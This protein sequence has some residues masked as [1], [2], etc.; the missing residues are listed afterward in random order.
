M[1]F[2]LISTFCFLLFASIG[3]GQNENNVLFL[4]STNRQFV[5]FVTIKDQAT[6]EVFVADSL[7]K[8]S[9]KKSGNFLASCIGFE[10]TEFEFTLGTSVVVILP[11]EIT[12][13]DM[14][15]ISANRQ[16]SKRTEAPIAIHKL[17]AKILDETKAT[18]VFEAI[19]KIPGVLT[20]NLNNEQHMMSIRLPVSTSA[21]YL[22]MEDGVPVRPMGVFNHNALI[23]FNQFTVSAIEVV[24]G[25]S[26]SIYGPEGIGGTINFISEK[27]TKGA[28]AKVGVQLD[29]WGYK[30]IQYALGLTKGKASLQLGGIYSDQKNSWMSRT[31]YTKNAFFGR[32]DYALTQKTNLNSTLSYSNYDSQT[33]GNIDSIGF[34]SRTYLA[35]NNFS[36]RKSYA[37]RLKTSLDHV[38]N[39]HTSS[40][41]TLFARNNAL[42][43]NPAYSIRWTTGSNTARGEINSNDFTSLGFIGQHNQK[44][45]FLKANLLLGISHDRSPN[46][47]NSYQIDLNAELQ[48]DK[49]SVKTY[50]IAKERPDIAL[51][52][53]KAIINNSAVYGQ[54]Q[55]EPIK[56]LQVTAGLRYDLM[57]FSFTN[58]IDVDKTTNKAL[59]G[60][61]VYDNLTP[62]VGLV[63][64]YS[65]K[66]GFYANYS[67]GFAPPSLTA[68]FR[69]RPAALPNGDLFY[70]NLNP[71][72]FTNQEVGLWYS[73]WKNKAYIDLSYYYMNGRNELLNIRQPDNSF[74]YQSAGK[75]THQGLEFS[76]NVKP[77]KQFTYRIGGAYSEHVF[78]EFLLSTRAADLVKNVNGK[79]MP[80]APQFVANSEVSY[81]PA[82]VKNSRISLE[83]QRVGSYFQNQIN[84][85]IYQ[86]YHL[87]NARFG[88]KYKMAEVYTNV[89]NLT[90][91]LYANN[92]SRGNA[93]TDRSNFTPA[94][95]RTYVIGLQF[96][97]LNP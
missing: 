87:W 73:F 62:K 81:Y 56:K 97:F 76:L 15:V 65:Q 26:S 51:A 86:G 71:A 47:Y 96:N 91:I 42:G 40:F 74:D 1:N 85:V 77:S 49:K 6:K 69:K 93:S 25:P 41:L 31:D 59:T 46:T 57:N 33:G 50:T 27:A 60:E 66:L 43:Q 22:Y 28:S 11:A 38:W 95:P 55:L 16:V 21:Y 13:L 34:Y 63:Y 10:T 68:I 45:T 37:L 8:F 64:N 2:R 30:R 39:K 61:K 52:N 75:T 35:N 4:E 3:F 70:Y 72:Q 24:K 90:D 89:L 18:G 80:N 92:V 44:F 94:A 84:T 83:Y 54:I 48:P 88:Y 20:A 82:I 32:F 9:L 7:G 78:N 29:Q 23:E 79:L 17:S 53:Y 19:N 5:P 12:F 58:N 36:Y 14:T 67:K